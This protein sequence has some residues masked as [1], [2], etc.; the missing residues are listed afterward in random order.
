MVYYLYALRTS[1]V[2]YCWEMMENCCYTWCAGVDHLLLVVLAFLPHLFGSL[3]AKQQQEEEEVGT[4]ENTTAAGD[5]EW[6]SRGAAAGGA[7]VFHSNRRV[8][9]LGK[10]HRNSFFL[11]AFWI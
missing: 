1:D 7:R 9:G 6:K 10:S 2:L 5:N 11:S 3:F 4:G 8:D